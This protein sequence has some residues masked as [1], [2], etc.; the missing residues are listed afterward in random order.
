MA[1]NSRYTVALHSLLL[2]EGPE[3]GRTSSEW[4]ASSVN[5]NPVFIRRILAELRDADLVEG[6][7]G[8]SGG[9]RLRRPPDEVTLWDVYRVFREEEGPF[10]LHASKP[11]PKCPVGGRI[12]KHLKIVYAEADE[13]MK[14]VLS[15]SSLASL[16]ERLRAG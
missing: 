16:R 10:A 7:H 14:K 11:N 4:I 8:R 9:Y 3:G 13:S 1:A 6:S 12:Q 15:R 5:T 2:L